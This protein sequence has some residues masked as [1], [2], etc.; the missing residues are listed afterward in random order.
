MTPMTSLRWIG[1]LAALFV[2]MI[3]SAQA[4]KQPAAPKLPGNMEQGLKAKNGV[5]LVYPYELAAERIEGSA[6]LHYYVREDGAA[7]GIEVEKASRAEFGQA[8]VAALEETRFEPEMASDGLPTNSRRQFVTVPFAAAQIDAVLLDAL[9][10][11]ETVVIGAREVDGGLKPLLLAPPVFP[12]AAARRKIM[13]GSAQI[14]FLI[15]PS[16][17]VRVPRIVSATAPEFGWSAASAVLLY[18]FAPPQKDGKP[19]LVR[20]SVPVSFQRPAFQPG[21]PVDAWD[22]QSLPSVIE[23]KAPVFPADLKQ[24]GVTG[25]V[26]VGFI[27]DERG[28]VARTYVLYSTERGFETPALEAVKNW[29]FKPAMRDGKPVAVR[30]AVPINFHLGRPPNK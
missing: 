6:T 3:V 22:M 25:M 17:A 11:P 4:P 20:V 21:Q 29:K 15:D 8:A 7:V 18:R 30:M 5:P 19:A 16:G 1:I 23:Q 28:M 24:R 10:K 13:S 14:E 12:E 27:V 2:G 26:D 9:K